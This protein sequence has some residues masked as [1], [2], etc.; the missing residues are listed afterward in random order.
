MTTLRNP[1]ASVA[2]YSLGLADKSLRYYTKQL[3]TGYKGPRETTSYIIGGKLISSAEVLKSVANAGQY[4]VSLLDIAT[5]ELTSIK[6]SLTELRTLI[7]QASPLS[8]TTI[9]TL[10]TVYQNKVGAIITKLANANFDGRNLFNGS[11]TSSALV[12]GQ[13]IPTKA[14]ALN[15]RAGD[16][17]NNTI[18]ISIPRL[19]SSILNGVEASVPNTFTPLFPTTAVGSDIGV[20]AGNIDVHGSAAVTAAAAA[21]IITDDYKSISGALLNPANLPALIDDLV[22][23]ATGVTGVAGPAFVASLANLGGAA[24]VETT[25][26]NNI[27]AILVNAASGASSLNNATATANDIS[28][29]IGASVN[30]FLSAGNLSTP[31]SR[32][33]ADA[34]VSNAIDTI[35]LTIASIS[36]QTS[37]VDETLDDL[38]DLA[39]SYEEAGN[40]YLLTKIEDASVETRSNLI[41]ILGI[42]NILKQGFDIAEATLTLINKN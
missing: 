2:K 33:N 10:N 3:A 41:K 38:A 13:G 9:G 30:S 18:S 20:V 42:I 23:G 1:V 25:I 5:S 39:V 31:Q 34:V 4:G 6:D 26:R 12:V 28:T 37:I 40:E 35:N 19:L 22:D 17:S 29:Y 21:A 15:L 14:S 16:A 36:G 8:A 24:V 27:I 11:I 32:T 7:A